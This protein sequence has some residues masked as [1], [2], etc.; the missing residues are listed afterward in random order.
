V[1]LGLEN[2]IRRVLNCLKVLD[3]FRS[4]DKTSKKQD[5]NPQRYICRMDKLKTILTLIAI[6]FVALVVLATIG[7]VY[8]ALYY[9]LIF[10]ILCL[11]MVIALRLLIKSS[12]QQIDTSKNERKKVGRI[13]DDYK[14]KHGL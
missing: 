2:L 10:G 5:V 3:S 11:G 12:Q 14:R 8:A 7:L 4:R 13:L 9:A 6:I 1:R